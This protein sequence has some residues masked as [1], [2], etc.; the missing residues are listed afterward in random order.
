MGQGALLIADPSA[1]D[2]PFYRLAPEWGRLPLVF[3]ATAATVIASQA[4]ISGAFSVTRQAVQ[5]GFL[6]RV[7]IRHTSEKEIGQVYVPAVNWALFVC[8]LALVA[9]F[10]SSSN[11]ASAYGIAVTGTLAIDTLLFF[12]VVYMLWK[13]PLWL[14]ITGAAFF[15]AIDLAFFSANLTKLPHGGWFPL[16]IAAIVFTILATWRK[17]REIALRRTSE[18]E[19]PLLEFLAR[20][21]AK[22]PH[23][24]SGYAVFLTASGGGAPP[25]LIYNLE[26]NRVLHEHVTLFTAETQTVPWVPETQRVRFEDIG[27]GL[28]RV[29]ASYGFQESPDIPHALEL[30]CEQGLPI[31]LDAVSYFLNRV[32]FLPTRGPGMPLWRKRL[33]GLLSRNATNAA[34]FFRLPSEQVI[35]I[36]T[37]VE[38]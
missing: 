35:E 27:Y 7:L 21:E 11:L 32:I 12:A 28:Y 14:A 19:V 5:L 36:G 3:L 4:V 25:A 33:F 2:N 37:R 1:V 38:I 15:L 16:A 30:A 8:V 13:K 18:Q 31:D 20:I 9:G 6:P 17:G 23:R 10:R 29:V 24:V 22:P 34:S 26:H